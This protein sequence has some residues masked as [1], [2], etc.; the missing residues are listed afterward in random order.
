MRCECLDH[1]LILYERQ[2]LR[3]AQAYVTY[4]NH[5]R[6]HQVIRQKIPCGGAA[7]ASPERGRV[8]ATS[9]LNGLHHK[10]SHRVLT[11]EVTARQAVR[12]ERNLFPC[13]P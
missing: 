7:R 3:A 10:F 4:F 13:K 5:A 1:L 12:N 6:P 8:I 2:L 9:V 11:T